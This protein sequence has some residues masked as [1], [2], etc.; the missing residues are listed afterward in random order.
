MSG[1]P[2]N[3]LRQ[4]EQSDF[5]IVGPFGGIQS[6]V[7]PDRIERLGVL[8][9][10]NIMFRKSGAYTRPQVYTLPVLNGSIVGA[11]DFF[12]VVGTRHQV[13]MTPTSAYV[14]NIGGNVFNILTGALTGAGNQLF[15]SAVVADKLLF[16]QGVDKVQ[17]W[18]GITAGF[19]PASANA[20][21]ARYLAELNFHLLACYT[22][23]AG[24]AVATQRV[25]WTGAGDPTDWT[26]F[27]SGN[28]D[29]F[30]DLGPITGITKLYQQAYIFQQWGIT[31]VIPTGNG[32]APFAFVPMGVK[33]KGNICPY[34]LSSFGEDI[35]CYIGKANIFSFDGNASVPIGDMPI[36]GS[37]QRAGARKRIFADLLQCAAQTV[38]GY[39]ST[40]IRGNDYGCYWIF[41]PE[42][43]SAWIYHFDEQ[44]WTRWT[45]GTSPSIAGDFSKPQGIRI[46][47]LV[48]TIAAQNWSPASLTSSSATDA[49]LIGFNSGVPGYVDFTGVSEQPWQITSGNGFFGDFKHK[50]T[51]SAV[52]LVLQDLQVGFVGT[53]TLTP[54]TA[55]ALPVSVT[56]GP[57][58]TASG[59]NIVLIVPFSGSNKVT[60]TYIQWKLSGAAG[61]Q[62]ALSEITPIFDVAGEVRTWNPTTGVLD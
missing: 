62:L 26:S 10:T 8:D 23:E 9:A 4:D 53:L 31:Q 7:P 43:Q 55:G 36:D 1:V 17:L 3:S 38:F 19:A 25:R 27:N 44:S 52:R 42:L 14:W 58:G 61:T 6:E 5:P 12:D 40:S 28:Q 16:C 59:N 13:V 29:L 57:I 30:N 60:G 21:P 50:K 11:A 15:T 24:P 56:F 41:M 47:D 18:D 39:I 33:A 2:P 20:V 54:N 51:V 22:V 32:L 37:R 49:M 35:A 46:M 34:S 48:G 45:F